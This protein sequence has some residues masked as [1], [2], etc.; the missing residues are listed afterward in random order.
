MSKTRTRAL[1]RPQPDSTLLLALLLL[2]SLIVFAAA[3]A[4]AGSC[5]EHIVKA[6]AE[7]KIPRGLLM[8]VS[9]VESGQGG[10]PAPYAVN[11]R[12]RA[13]YP[14]SEADAARQLRDGKGKLR[15]SVFAGCMQLSVTHHKAAF[16]PVEKIV[17]PE[18][19]VRYAARYLVQLRKESGSWAGAVARY[20]GAS[21]KKAQV[22]QCKVRRQLASLGADAVNL[23]DAKACGTGKSPA[24]APKTRRAYQQPQQPATPTS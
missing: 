4:R 11:V 12:G 3:P 15:G 19:N 16:S 5:V 9:L 1:A 20:N 6:E 10:Y 2:V 17:N 21:S 23:F 7:F 13:V 18:Q 14:K 22:Y 24:I 8:A